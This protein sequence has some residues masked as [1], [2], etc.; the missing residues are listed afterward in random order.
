MLVL[1]ITSSATSIFLLYIIIKFLCQP[2]PAYQPVTTN[3]NNP[4]KRK[5]KGV[6]I[7]RNGYQTVN[8]GNDRAVTMNDVSDDDFDESDISD[9]NKDLTSAMHMQTKTQ[10]DNVYIGDDL[11]SETDVHVFHNE[12]GSDD[13]E[14]V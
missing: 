6:T 5:A 7:G 10:G 9:M 3:A 8:I 12:N 14:V 2:A 1:L 4:Y 13:D 11:D